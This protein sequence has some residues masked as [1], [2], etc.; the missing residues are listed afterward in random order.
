MIT[1]L[2]THRRVV[3]VLGIL[4]LGTAAALPAAAQDVRL[5]STTVADILAQFPGDSS[6]KRNRLADDIL[7]LGEP[8]IA[9]FAKKLVPAGTGNDTAVRFAL[10]AVSVY[11]SQAGEPKRALAERALCAALSGASDTEVRTFL[12]SQLRP[13]GRDV[14]VRAAVPLLSDSAMVEPATQ[15]LLT[16]N[17]PA[18]RAALIGA[19]GRAAG[20]SKLTLVKALGEMK[21][22]EANDRI[23]ALAGDPDVV[24][25]KTALAALAHI[26]SAQ[27]YTTMVQA[28]ERVEFRYEPAN[29]TAALIEYAKALAKKGDRATAERIA[30]LVMTKTDDAER[31][32]TRVAAL[33]VLVDVRGQ[34][35]LSD[36]LAAVDH[37]D[38]EY[39]KGALVFAEKLRAPTAVR[40]WTAKADTVDAER[41]AEIILMLGRQ[42]DK[43]SAAYIR[44]ALAA[45]DPVVMMAAAESLAHLERGA[46]NAD[47]LALL[48]RSSDDQARQIG[49]ILLWTT[50]EA[51]LEP[52]A[53]ALDTLSPSAKAA[54][55]RVIG[56]KS[57][58]RYAA[59]VFA[60]TSDSNPEVRAAAIGAL[61][62]V[63]GA[64]DLPALLRLLETTN[65]AALI[66]DVQ[67]GVATSARQMMPADAGAKALVDAMKTATHPERIIEVLPQVGGPQA[68]AALVE[69]VNGPDIKGTAFRGLVDWRGPEASDRLL[70]I[71]T[72]GEPAYRD[73]AFNGFVRQ[74]SSSSLP[75]EQRVLQVRKA[76]GVATTARERRALIRAMGGMKTYQAFLVGSSYL[77]NA[78][79]ANDAANAVMRIVL[80]TPG[81]RD[82]LSGA[83]VR[84][85]LNRVLQVLTGGE[86][87]YDK[88]N[89]RAY[90]K[91]MPQGEGFVAM[92][93]GK[94][95]TG[96]KG[97]VENPIARVKMTPQELATR[98][99]AAD[100]NAKTT[101]S[102]RDGTI[103]FNGKGD[104]LCSVKDYGDVEMIVDWRITKDGDSGIYL[105]GSPQV[106]IWDPARTDVGAEV[107]SGGLY[108]NQ[109]NPSKPLVF[110]DNPVG[111]WNTFRILMI[112]D[113]V[114]V[115]LNGTKVVDNVTL[116][117]YWDRA[118]PI[119][120]RGAIELQA[121]G[122]DLAFRDI[123]VRELD[124]GGH[125]LSDQERAEGFVQLFNGRNLDGWIG[126]LTGYKVEDGVM[127]YNP[128]A[129]DRSNIYAAKQ[130][131]DFAF[132]FEFQLTPAANNGVGIRTPNEGDA[133][134]VG[135]E[136]QILDDTAPV[137]ETLQ[138]YQYHGSVYGVIP[139]KRGAL[140]P[141]GEWN[142]EE[143]TIRGS[144][145]T[146]TVNGVVT[147]D[148]D[149]VEA[150]KNGT[151]DKKEHPGLRRTSGYIGLLSHDSVVR[152]RNIRIKAQ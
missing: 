52:V 57:G 67:K 28:A 43:A 146:V 25:R 73:Q 143:I 35:A 106:Q 147:V 133:A 50:D 79:L 105:R 132:R 18:A 92:F 65:E 139:A 118:R 128:N 112:A 116:E 145:I 115:Y 135:M 11:A 17:S 77:D 140:K 55:V 134:Y 37:Q 150:S 31:L 88:E 27:S 38:P 122:T 114:T 46:A 91:T 1:P 68:L 94:D 148:G 9:E 10:N 101:W 76:L 149:L 99:A 97:L 48:K 23:L 20:P 129:G 144:R 117:N 85:A 127:V 40:Q 141:V 2:S 152:F 81:A 3:A 96:W 86:S 69:R 102:V 109:K 104:N 59:R 32:P 15:L 44:G 16:V 63:A 75:D 113:K 39:R 53:A 123:Y 45:K 90:L 49:D 6:A 74:V 19:L 36:L 62:G 131:S 138:P 26:A 95:L 136:I 110:A 71:Y 41:R 29:A 8:G 24:M 64:D 98:Q 13:V 82:G 87:D 121:H 89:I 21:A 30:R 125:A 119:F 80:P 5:L 142:A 84:D 120:P 12:L 78:D 4:L 34:A 22:A 130:Y 103:V 107:G 42:G 124:G 54:A 51:S 126:N 100:A 47:L 58:R 66:D 93:N 14:A 33:A 72:S 137:Y 7:A 111:E 83:L 56:A 108:N 60:L 70:A 151:I 61:A